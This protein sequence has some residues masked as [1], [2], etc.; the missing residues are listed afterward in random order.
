MNIKRLSFSEKNIIKY[1]LIIVIILV[2]AFL[3]AIFSLKWS[4]GQIISQKKWLDPQFWGTAI[5]FL[6]GIIFTVIFQYII[7]NY[8]DF[9]L[10]NAT[11]KLNNHLKGIRGE[12]KTFIKLKEILGQEY[13]VYRNFKI[14]NRKF[15][16]DAIIVGPKGI[17]AIEIKNI[18]GEFEFIGEETYKRYMNYN[19]ECVCKLNEQKSPTKQILRHSAVLEKWLI[20]N[21][22][23]NILLKRAIILVNEKVKVNKIKNPS[24]FIVK[25]LERLPNFIE[26]CYNDPLFTL[27]FCKKLNWFLSKK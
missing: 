22:F 11:Q 27:E 17:I 1:S 12:K 23:R 19:N 16:V 10:D 14:P 4:L 26:T 24:V 21:G 20:E 7:N 5:I 9:W 6:I 3:V 15:D 18:S 2:F 8:F 13:K 25:G